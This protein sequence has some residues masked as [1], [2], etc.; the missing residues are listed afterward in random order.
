MAS[1]CPGL[2]IVESN[3]SVTARFVDRTILNDQK[4]DAT[5]TELFR[6]ADVLG[7]RELRLDFSKVEYVQSSVLGK[8]VHLHKQVTGDGNRL[9]L[10]C[11]NR[12]VFKVFAVT[13]LE[14]IFAFDADYSDEGSNLG[15][16]A[17]A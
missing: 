2:E 8:L 1:S 13:R 16:P 4:M 17:K 3:E 5:A 11:L 15:K 9:V 6:L 12:G 7:G 14:R 10:C